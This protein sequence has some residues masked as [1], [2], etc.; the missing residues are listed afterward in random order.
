[1]AA[2]V[3]LLPS[4]TPP[5]YHRIVSPTLHIPT[6]TSR[7]IPV[8]LL[9]CQRDPLLRELV[10]TIISSTVSQSL[11]PPSNGSQG[12]KNAT[13]STPSEPLVEIILHDTIIFP[14]GGGQPSDIGTLTSEDG[15]LWNVIEVK[16]H[17]GHAV[18]YIRAKTS[19]D[20]ALR[21]FAPGTRVGVALGEEGWKRRLDHTCMH[22]S[23]HL[24]SAVLES[25]LNLSTLSWSITAWPSAC[26]VEIPR[27][28][29]ADEIARIQET[30][31]AIVF[32][33]RNVHVEVEELDRDTLP[34]PTKLES[35]RAAGQVLPADYT[36][37]V[38]RTVVI[39]GIDRS[40][41]CGTHMPTVHNLQLF[42]VPHTEALARSNTTSA[43]LYF[44]SGPRLLHHVTN[45]HTLLSS[46]AGTLS[47]GPPLV[48]ARVEQ[49]VDERKRT[50]KRVEDVEAELAGR[51]AKDLADAVFSAGTAGAFLHV[52]RTDDP[53]TAGGALGFLNAVSLAFTR[54]IER[55]A[56]EEGLQYVVVL[57]SAPAGQSAGSTC[58]ILV[59][60]SDESVVRSVG[61]GL[62]GK[63]GVKGGGKG[64]RWSG[65]FTGV[66][67]EYREGKLVQEVLAA[68]EG[69]QAA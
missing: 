45:T 5:T 68:V 11:S 9:A 29:S 62:K 7:P 4:V 6:D 55:E 64:S 21:A 41:C 54:Q 20:D 40:L 28:M 39:D 16:R 3:S 35:G 56:Q 12:K 36:G 60:G 66:W 61:E 47:C 57:S 23:Q 15:D 34:E 49:L 17:G 13:K 58:V 24:L 22:T 52:H 46:T 2:A 33:G 51:L 53:A 31:N 19:T 65:K 42:L 8:G 50:A 32:E 14:E 67:K 37:G 1:M 48:P 18:H 38:K 27:G 69:S 26:Y 44:F 43:R 25:Q 59:F 63:L 30:A 10:T